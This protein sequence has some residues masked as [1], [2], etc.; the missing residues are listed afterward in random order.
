M[1]LGQAKKL[2]DDHS[3]RFYVYVLKK[4]SGIP[5]YVGKGTHDRIACHEIG[6]EFSTNAN[7]KYYKENI[8]RKILKNGKQINYDI[9]LFINDEKEAY[10]KEIE[11]IKLY[12]RK[13]NHTGILANLTDGGE[14]GGNGGANK[15]QK[16]SLKSRLK[17]SFSHI[18]KPSPIK[19]CKLTKEHRKKLS[20]SHKGHKM[21]EEQRRKISEGNKK[22]KNSPEYIRKISEKMSGRN[23]PFYGKKHTKETRLKMSESSKKRNY[24]HSDEVKKKISEA[25]LK[26]WERKKRNNK[27]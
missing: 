26:M 10:N 3:E 11:I 12:G 1:N 18:G 27:K 5:F 23:N 14:S 15:G 16:R 8:I 7:V 2:I 9:I 6:V 20:E 24:K 25:S 17:M 13:N 4:P 22:T 21:P 19:G